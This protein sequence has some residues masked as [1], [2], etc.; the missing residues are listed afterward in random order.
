M[1]VSAP[2]NHRL[3]P[4]AAPALPV[5]PGSTAASPHCWAWQCTGPGTR[6]AV[7][8]GLPRSQLRRAERGN[9]PSW[10]ARSPNECPSC[11]AVSSR[12]CANP[13][14]HGGPKHRSRCRNCPQFMEGEEGERCGAQGLSHASGSSGSAQLLYLPTGAHTMPLNEKSTGKPTATVAGEGLFV[15][16]AVGV[17]LGARAVC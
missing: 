6:G 9:F 15:S 5:P 11:A 2:V 1:A 4:P 16:M 3:S 12:C 8:K 17:G 7:G 14:S 10:R 13:A